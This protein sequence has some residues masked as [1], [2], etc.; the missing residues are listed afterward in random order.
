ML[1]TKN[2]DELELL[3][4][5]FAECVGGS[6]RLVL[7]SGGLATGKTT[8]LHAF[9]EHAGEHGALVLTAAGAR[10]ERALRLGVIWQ[11][12]RSAGL[13]P[14]ALDEVSRIFDFAPRA[15]VENGP[16]P[17]T[18]PLADSDAVRAV[19]SALRALAG[20]R[21]IA[22][23]VDDLQFVDPVSLQI[24]LYL[25]RSMNS[26]RLMMVLTE[27]ERPGMARPLLRAELTRQPHGQINV[28]P[29]S[30]AGVMEFVSQRL[31]ARTAALVAPGYYQLSG[32]NPLLTNALIEDHGRRG[33]DVDTPV[34][35]RAF[36]S[37]VL[38]CL[39]RWDP[40]FRT[41]AGGLAVLGDRATPDIVA[42][43]VGMN[44]HT[45]SQILDVL[46]TAGL[47]TESGRWRH[48]EI[49]LTVV[50]SL[51]PE[52]TTRLHTRAAEILHRH[53]VDAEEI[54]GHLLAAGSAPGPWASRVLQY[55]ADQS[56]TRDTGLAV[57]Y[58]ELA[59]LGGADS[60]ELVALRSALVRVA[61]RA[62][63]SVVARHLPPLEDKLYAGE[64]AWR[65]AV[66][67][68]RFHLWQG[69]VGTAA[70]QIQAMHDLTGPSDARTTAELRLA[71]EWIYGS[72]HDRV[73]DSVRAILTATDRTTGS[74]SP[75]LRTATVNRRWACG[76]SA[77]VA[78]TAEHIL[79][80]CLG[81]VLPEVGATALMA[82]DD[83]NRQGRA[84]L[85][86]DTLLAETS[87]RQ[88]TT[89]QAVLG[90]VRADL[91]WRR[92][93]LIAAR[94]RAS[95]ALDLLSTQC[96]GV[97]IGLPLSI[98]V[99]TD[100]AM[101]KPEA[102]AETLDRTVPEA[103]FG[104]A[105]GARYLHARGT[106]YLTTGKTLAAVDDFERCGAWLRGGESDV[107]TVVPWRSDLAWAYLELGM[108][109]QAKDLV[110]DQLKR[111]GAKDSSRIRA[112]ALR[113]LASCSELNDRAPLLREAIQLLEGCT[114]RLEMIRALADLSQVHCDLGEMGNARLVMRNAEQLANACRAE[115][116]PA[117]Q[118][119]RQDQPT[120]DYRAAEPRIVGMTAL[121]QAE[122]KVAGLAAHGHTN[123]EISR[124]LYITVS[125]VEQHLTR[126]YKKLNV[127][128][129]TD[130]AAELLPLGTS[131]QQAS[132]DAP[133]MMLLGR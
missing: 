31:G 8:L 38:D 4:A 101:G 5:M 56:A 2:F 126:V 10:T 118:R 9:L 60:H 41:V 34:V 6:G 11:L 19:C 20:D 28:A 61:W 72:L 39:H 88:A 79:Q 29:L 106:Y 25:R 93:D 18:V 51:S 70:R 129:R 52:D 47:V 27:W 105:F 36:R 100:I 35:G 102:A 68:I 121:S 104:T 55:A 103:M 117:R 37:A 30:E 26:D 119:G 89:W 131:A 14:E 112:A 73:P 77:D 123:R 133:E 86:C 74:M 110:Q 32:G 120:R 124:K 15:P 116:L 78:S 91:A 66:P 48:S 107:P 125:T 111:R 40:E 43:L 80:S 97:L 87:Q 128:G 96:W 23:G 16:E 85:W 53:G 63:P 76:A 7:I 82:L 67:M 98:L 75:W 24:L 12:F 22:I 44:P 1:L 62:N 109:K 99:L 50:E 49:T 84:R 90:C 108:R 71:C 3:P 83:I 113:V 57:K 17:S 45:V 69:D 33:E 42:E 13:K 54:A 81:D 65:D 58:L 115:I 94:S 114:D 130:L 127:S 64:L 122:R 95:A 59:M 92:G 21:P 132:K 46:Q